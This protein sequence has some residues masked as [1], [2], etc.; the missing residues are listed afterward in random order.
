MSIEEVQKK[1]QLAQANLAHYRAL[2]ALPSLSRRAALAAQESAR[3]YQA[4]VTLYQKALAYE[5]GKA[6]GS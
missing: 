5:Q 6:Q 1:L 2:A 3:S 4:A